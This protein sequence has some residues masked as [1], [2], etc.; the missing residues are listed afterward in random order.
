MQVGALGTSDQCG[1]WQTG[2]AVG[3]D[4]L[5]PSR[6]WLANGFPLA[7]R[8]TSDG[9][10][11]RVPPPREPYRPIRVNMGEVRIR[12]R[13]S[14]EAL[15]RRCSQATP[16]GFF[17]CTVPD[18]WPRTLGGRQSHAP[19]NIFPTV[20]AVRFRRSASPSIM[21]DGLPR[22]GRLT[23]AAHGPRSQPQLS[24]G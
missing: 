12:C 21:R 5:K 20:S 3:T 8:H 11:G 17:L 2:Q 23:A 19:T 6:G 18:Q 4:D 22:T 7:S 1:S 16:L 24:Q 10:A 13:S 14:W 9:Y 15:V